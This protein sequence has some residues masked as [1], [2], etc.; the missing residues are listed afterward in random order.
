MANNQKNS[1]NR[2]E[3]LSYLSI[4]WIALTAAIGGLASL[5]FR[6]SYPNVDFDPEMEFLAGFPWRIRRRRR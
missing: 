3:F 4:G 6:Y 1:L 2:R 5:A